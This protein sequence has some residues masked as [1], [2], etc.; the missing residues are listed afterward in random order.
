MKLQSRR[1][2][3]PPAC[4]DYMRTQQHIHACYST[5]MLVNALAHIQLRQTRNLTGSVEGLGSGV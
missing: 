1:M 2:L 3:T 5:Y 4:V